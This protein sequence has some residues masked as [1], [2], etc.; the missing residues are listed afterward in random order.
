MAIVFFL[1]FRTIYGQTIDQETQ[2]CLSLVNETR[3]DCFILRFLAKCDH[4][5]TNLFGTLK[6]RAVAT[7]TAEL[8]TMFLIYS[9][10][11]TEYPTKQET[12]DILSRM[13]KFSQPS[14]ACCGILSEAFYKGCP[15]SSAVLNLTATSG[16][17]P[18]FLQG[19]T[20]I[21]SLAC[22]VNATLCPPALPNSTATGG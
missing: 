11:A 13:R 8:D 22:R 7:C 10:G 21:L 12:V 2:Q 17:S 20:T 3:N 9:Q 16:V 1:D 19:A 15:C 5:L 6:I 18:V 4:F 14:R